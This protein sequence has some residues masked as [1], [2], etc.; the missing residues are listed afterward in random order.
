[1][2]CN[3][4][5]LKESDLTEQLSTVSSTDG[6]IPLMTVTGVVTSAEPCL[7]W[8]PIQQTLWEAHKRIHFHL[9]VTLV[10]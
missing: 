3:P 5:G 2:G 1:M 4:W 10:S 9:K 7:T 6:G 8:C